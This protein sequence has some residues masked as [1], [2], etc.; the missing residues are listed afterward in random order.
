MIAERELYLSVL[1]PGSSYSQSYR[2]G[3]N[4]TI[5]MNND[6]VIVGEI[7]Q[8]EKD[9]IVVQDND[10][11]FKTVIYKDMVKIADT[12]WLCGDDIREP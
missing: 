12:D 10:K 4:V 8:I 3:Q 5:L 7:Q 2:L 9:Y 6:K 1:N 11:E